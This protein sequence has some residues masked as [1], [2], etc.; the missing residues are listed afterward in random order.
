M[1]I[2]PFLVASAILLTAA[3]PAVSPAPVVVAERAFAK[4][5]AAM[6]VGPSFLK[7]SEPDA[8]MIGPS[9]LT[10]PKEAFGGSPPTGPQ[11]LLAWWPMWAG[12]AQ[13]GDLGFTTGPVEV[14]GQRQGHY[15]TVWR[16]QAGGDWR[17]VYDGGTGATSAGEPPASSEPAYLPVSKAKPLAHNRAGQAVDQVE[18]DLARAARSNLKSAFA[19]ILAPE[20]RMYVAP[21]PPAI[22]PDA[23][24][25]AL[26]AYPATLD[27]A[28]P[29]GGASSKAGDL[30]YVFGRVKGTGVN[31]YYVHLWQRRPEGMKLVFAQIIPTRG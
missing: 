16:R 19:G 4:D 3:A 2:L 31:G 6:G 13:S 8:V 24:A 10:R 7:W 15:F 20:A 23:I 26:S 17:W 5:G 12:I 29:A 30:I 21:R 27:F 11:P 25:Q 22:G 18:A 9:G 1:R 14:G 28:P